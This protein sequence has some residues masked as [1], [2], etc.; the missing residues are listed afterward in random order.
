MGWRI[1]AASAVGSSHLDKG[2]PCQDA[3][4]FHVSGDVLAAVVC[5]GAGSAAHSDIG[6]RLIADAL[7]RALGERL[8]REPELLDAPRETFFAAAVEAVAQAREGVVERAQADGRALGDYAA[9]VVGYAGDARRGWFL[10]IGDGIGVAEAASDDEDAVVSLP[11]NGEYANETYF[12]TGES[13]REQLR[14]LPVPAPTA[15]LALMSDGAMPFAMA[16]GNAELYAPFIDPVSRY[17]A[18]VD[19][20]EGSRALH[21]TLADPRTHGITSDDKTLLI[22]L[23]V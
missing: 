15:R 17:L 3:C 14:V 8:G 1:Y 23:R 21:G 12:V 2:I 13:W 11:A 7:A 9:T 16:R 20:A 18:S 10:H 6:A 5:D 22:A 4:A 19:E